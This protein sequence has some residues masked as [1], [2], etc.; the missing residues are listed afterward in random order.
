M[1]KGLIGTILAL[2]CHQIS[3]MKPS[4]IYYVSCFYLFVAI[5]NFVI[6][7]LAIELTYYAVYWAIKL[8]CFTIACFQNLCPVRLVKNLFHILICS[9]KIWFLTD[10][11]LFGAPILGFGRSLL[12]A[13]QKHFETP[14][15]FIY[16][17]CFSAPNPYILRLLNLW[18][19]PLLGFL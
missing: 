9:Y 12:M 3:L 18:L 16:V 11:F 6:L 1:Q 13:S 7:C 15:C 5:P 2:L 10:F 4:S 19:Y 8:P 14:I 17:G